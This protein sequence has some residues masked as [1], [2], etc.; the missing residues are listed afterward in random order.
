[1]EEVVL[2]VKVEGTGDGEAKIKSVK[3]QLREAKEAA[4]Q[5]KEGTEEYFQALQKAAGLADQLQDVNKAINTLDPGAKAQAFGNLINGIAGG[6]QT[7]TGLY[8][9]MGQKSQ[10]VEKL[11]L[12]VQSAS[13][14]A[15]GVQSLVEAGKQWKNIKAVILDA[16]WA[17][18]LYTLA[19]GATTGAM[20]ALRL[21]IAATGIGALA[22]VIYEL[23]VNTKQSIAVMD[24]FYEKLGFLG[25]ILK[26][27]PSLYS[28]AKGIDYL[29]ERMGLGSD[30]AGDYEERIKLV[31]EALDKLVTAELK[32]RN[33][34]VGG[35]NDIQRQ[36]KLLQAQ[37]KTAIETAGLEN[38]LFQIK[39]KNIDDEI[40]ARKTYNQDVTDL[41]QQRKD[42]ENENLVRQANITKLIAEELAKRKKAY[43]DEFKTITE[44]D[45][46]ARQENDKLENEKGIKDAERRAKEL[47]DVK[48]HNQELLDATRIAAKETEDVSDKA[49]KQQIADA[50]AVRNAKMQIMQNTI[51]G[52]QALGELVQTN[53]KK[54]TAFQKTLALA[55]IALSTAMGIA[56]AVEGAAK[57]SK[58]TGPAA[59]FT[60]VAYIISGIASVVAGMASAKRALSEPAISQVGGGGGTGGLPSASGLTPPQIQS[61][62]NTSSFLLQDEANFKVYVLESDITNSQQGVQQNKKKALLTI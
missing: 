51:N 19:V 48:K 14:I 18:Q 56:T 10:E 31:G 38:K 12:K 23:T 58:D 49:K 13:A 16:A 40:V 39:I 36:I 55:Q 50:E 60:L 8:G 4:L 1:M 46:K 34:A 43:E 21:A 7:I 22:L 32:R 33:A 2:K 5:A 53:G 30:A 42:L 26:Y 20:K 44:L 37:G 59:P 52:L 24:K 17:Q 61:P 15:M 41:E 47:D 27:V 35:A 57:A 28:V 25:K 6:F 11:L 54:Q 3:Q 29:K 9:L 62:Q 45:V